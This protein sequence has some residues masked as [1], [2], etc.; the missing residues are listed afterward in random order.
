MA[1]TKVFARGFNWEVNTGTVAA[2]VWVQ[3]KGLSQFGV[4]NS[5][6]NAE[7]TDNQSAGWAEHMVSERTSQFTLEGFYLED[8]ANGTRD[9][10]QAGVEAAAEKV[11]EDSLNQFRMT[12]PGGKIRTFLASVEVGFNG[13]KNAPTAWTATLDLSGTITKVN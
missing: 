4:S 9:P 7:T 12:T 6:E 8:K 3:I 10:G 13:D 11:G 2:P 1:I 5:K